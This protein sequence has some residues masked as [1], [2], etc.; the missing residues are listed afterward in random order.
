MLSLA[1]DRAGCEFTC[2]GI[3]S[4]FRAQLVCNRRRRGRALLK[5]SCSA[6]LMLITYIEGPIIERRR[7]E[8]GKT[9][10]GAIGCVCQG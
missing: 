4:L 2:L 9:F 6:M 10:S 5:A 7:D 1:V 8:R 3:A